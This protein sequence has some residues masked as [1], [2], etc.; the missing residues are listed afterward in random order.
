MMS[1]ERA[2][3]LQ[4]QI[5]LQEIVRCR[6]EKR[7]EGETN[8]FTLKMNIGLT[9]CGSL[10]HPNKLKLIWQKPKNYFEY[11]IIYF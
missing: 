6:K 5:D 8:Q 2:Q 1:Q 9:T 4:H 7:N 11:L 10:T 3:R